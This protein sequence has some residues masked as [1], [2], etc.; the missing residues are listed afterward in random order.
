MGISVICSEQRFCNLES[1]RF[2]RAVITNKC[3]RMKV[4]WSLF[5]WLIKSPGL[6]LA[7][8]N[9][10]SALRALFLLFCR[11]SAKQV[12]DS[13]R[14]LKLHP[15]RLGALS[16]TCLP[17]RARRTVCRESQGS[18]PAHQCVSERREGF[19][20]GSSQQHSTGC[21]DNNSCWQERAA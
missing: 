20:G 9:K 3:S 17:F 2:S 1:S 18:T 4:H 5:S 16:E 6:P 14:G 12:C 21:H 13:S 8:F 19:S 15:E 10:I 11:C 7:C